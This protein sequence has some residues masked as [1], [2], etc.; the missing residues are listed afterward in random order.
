MLN[1][2]ELNEKYLINTGTNRACY[3]H[4]MNKNQCIKITISGNNKETK[5]EISCYKNLI[6]KKISWDMLAKYYGL[7]DTNYGQGEVV[8]LIRDYDDKISKELAYYINENVLEKKYIN[9]LLNKLEIYLKNEMIIVKDL[10]TVNIVYQK[11]SEKN[12]GRLV[13]I[14]GIASR[15]NIFSFNFFKIKKIKTIWNDFITTI[16]LNR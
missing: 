11:F 14:D 15:K 9:T 5:R 4:P 16:E 12:N 10:N 13:I 7:V 8:E 6:D 1:I 3:V 2:I